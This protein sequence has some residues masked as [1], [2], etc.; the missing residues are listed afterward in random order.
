MTFTAE[1]KRVLLEAFEDMSY[2]AMYHDVHGMHTRGQV[3]HY[4]SP[5]VFSLVRRYRNNVSPRPEE[6]WA[7]IQDL[8]REAGEVEEV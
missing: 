4:I 5:G 1:E 2:D 8:Q 7:F 3:P 6:F